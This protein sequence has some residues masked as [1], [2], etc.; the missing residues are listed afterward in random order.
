MPFGSVLLPA[1][2]AVQ[3][4]SSIQEKYSTPQEAEVDGFLVHL[5]LSKIPDIVKSIRSTKNLSK[6]A[7][8][9]LLLQ[10]RRFR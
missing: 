2:T 10:K 3:V 8:K 6:I 9:E 1:S 7:C 4:I 5:P